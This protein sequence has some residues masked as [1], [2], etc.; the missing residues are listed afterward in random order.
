MGLPVA[1]ADVGILDRISAMQH[2]GAAHID[3]T[4]G[5]SRRVIRP[6]EKYQVAGTGLPHRSAVVIKPLGPQAAHVPARM[7]EHPGHEAGAVKGRGRAGA[8]PHIGIADVFCGLRHHRGKGFIFQ[9]LRGDFIRRGR[10]GIIFPHIAGLR[11][12]VGPVAQGCHVNRIPG[13]L[14]LVHHLH[15]QMGQVVIFQRDSADEIV[16]GHLVLV[17]VSVLVRVCFGVVGLAKEVLNVEIYLVCW[18]KWCR[19]IYFVSNYEI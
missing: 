12:Q 18:G 2:C 4:V 1:G 13:K 3:A 16:V 19:K 14:F 6:F 17:L 10:A 9:R 8:A 7:V 15:G 5:D 11:E